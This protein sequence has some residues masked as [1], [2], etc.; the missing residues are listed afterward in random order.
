MTADSEPYAIG[1]R[2]R[3]I[4]IRLSWIAGGIWFIILAPGAALLIWLVSIY[5]SR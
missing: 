5:L 1:E 2:R 4:R 3:A